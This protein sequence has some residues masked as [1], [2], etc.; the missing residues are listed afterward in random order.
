[1]T[2]DWQKEL[3]DEFDAQQKAVMEAKALHDKEADELKRYN[4]EAKLRRE[5]AKLSRIRNHMVPVGAKVSI[6]PYTDWHSYTIVSR[7]KDT[8]TARADRQT[9]FKTSW[10]DGERNCEPNP[11]GEIIRLTWSKVSNC[12]C[13]NIYKV[14][15]GEYNYEDPSF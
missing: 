11:N 14:M 1:M 10:Q 6:S 4:L 3:Q 9:A 13:Y 7:T 8:L 15:I 5:T 12:W 2:K